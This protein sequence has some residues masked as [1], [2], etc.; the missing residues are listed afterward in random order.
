MVGGEAAAVFLAGVF[1]AALGGE[2]AARVLPAFAGV[3]P[4]ETELREL[5]ANLFGGLLGER[6]PNPLAYNF[7]QVVLGGHPTAEKVKHLVGRQGAVRLALGEV[8]IGEYAGCLRCAAVFGSAPLLI[9]PALEPRTPC[10][11]C[12]LISILFRFHGVFFSSLLLSPVSRPS[13]NKPA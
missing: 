3:V 7:G 11:A 9:R 6:N 12:Q 1:M 8:H 10:L 13:P 4:M 5:A 2:L